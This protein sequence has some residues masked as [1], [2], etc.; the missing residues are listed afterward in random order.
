[1]VVYCGID[2][3]KSGAI[4]WICGSRFSA[5]KMPDTPRGLYFLMRDTYPNEPRVVTLE[6][7][8]A[9]PGID[10]VGEDSELKPGKG[11]GQFRGSLSNAK[12]MQNYGVIQG[13]LAALDIEPHEVAPLRWQNR[14]GCRTGGNKKVTTE[15]A[16]ALFPQVKIFG[17]N[18]DAYLLAHY[19]RLYANR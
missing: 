16:R 7:Q 18:A 5:D 2:P 8:W 14:L 4:A 9:R 17:W 1:M 12:L 15:H 3:G 11:K 13:V 19:G 10:K 6:M